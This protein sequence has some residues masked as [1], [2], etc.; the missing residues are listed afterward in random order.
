MACVGKA[1][2]IMWVHT[3]VC[4]LRCEHF[5]SVWASQFSCKMLCHL[6]VSVSMCIGAVVPLQLIH[7]RCELC[8]ISGEQSACL[9]GKQNW[10]YTSRNVSQR[11]GWQVCKDFHAVSI[12]KSKTNTT[13]YKNLN[14]SQERLNKPHCIILHRMQWS[15]GPVRWDSDKPGMHM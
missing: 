12:S 15:S 14:N 1:T 4:L 3:Y 6:D 10:T 8:D 7:R 13:N 11:R 5:W 2:C 9:H